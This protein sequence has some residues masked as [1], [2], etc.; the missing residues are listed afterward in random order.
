MVL[1]ASENDTI[2]ALAAPPGVGGIGVLRISGPQAPSILGQ[3]YRGKRSP[4]DWLSHR[5]YW[6][7]LAK[8]NS[9]EILD[10]GLVVWMKAP[11]SFT[12]EEVVEIHAHGGPLILNLILEALVESGLRL[13]EPGEFTRR[14]FFR[15]KLDLLQAE[16]V[17]EMIHA[18]SEAAL[19][20]ARAQ[21]QGRIS[22][23]VASLRQ[24]LLTLLSR[25]EAAID[26]PE[27]DI[28]ILSPAQSHQEIR[29]IQANLSEWLDKFDVGR[30][31]RE[32]VKLALMGRPN[33]GKS[34]LLNRLSG[35]EKA[36]VHVRPGTTR[37]VI[38][39]KLNLEG[40]DCQ[41]FDTAGIREGLEDVEREGIARSKKAAAHADLCLW[42]LDA[43]Q[44]L[45]PEDL[46]ILDCL[47]EKVLPVGNKV[48][49]GVSLKIFPPEWPLPACVRGKEWAMISAKTGEGLPELKKRIIQEVGLQGLENQATGYLNNARHRE[50]LRQALGFLKSAE[51]AIEQNRPAECLAFDLKE[52]AG[53]LES[54]LGKISHEEVLDK[55]F[56][57]FCIGK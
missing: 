48:D 57:D 42:V 35:E 19:R 41:I 8:P 6:G 20:N 15:G 44:A 32:G 17:G 24:R 27:E 22:E 34:S 31:L 1:K 10:T 46:A 4:K 28:E 38:E 13:A 43:S 5:L 36:I 30:L 14:A 50:A 21:L 52:A 23:A 49:Q 29:K 3:V 33:V 47:P 37:D 45:G 55:I 18:Q 25:V 53:A 9:E 26:F 16:A 54:L 56:S 51:Q 2:V 39:A 11:A 40:I 12:G 7:P